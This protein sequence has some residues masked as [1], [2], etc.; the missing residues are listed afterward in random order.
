MR[1][2]I[3]KANIITPNY[4][5]AA[6]LLNEKYCEEITTQEIKEW[7]VRLAEMGPETV[8]ITSAPDCQVRKNTCVM[9]YNRQDG[10]FWKVSCVYIP[11]HY[12]GGDAF[13]RNCR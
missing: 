7:L 6:F 4:T 5:E 8:I 12:P 3:A 2:L 10:R 11:A 13:Q 1:Q 9:A